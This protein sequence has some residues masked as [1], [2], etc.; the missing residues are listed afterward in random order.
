[1]GRAIQFLCVFFPFSF[2]L[3]LPPSF[4]LFQD[5]GAD[6]TCGEMALANNVLG[7]Q[8]SETAL[9][10]RHPC[11]DVFG[12]QV[13][14]LP[15]SLLPSPFPPPS[16]LLSCVLLS[17]SYTEALVLILPPSLPPSL[18]SCSSLR[19]PR[20][21]RGREGGRATPPPTTSRN[22]SCTSSSSSSSGS[23]DDIDSTS[24]GEGGREGGLDM[25]RQSRNN[26]R[27][28]QGCPPQEKNRCDRQ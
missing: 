2:R 5:L 7:G 26:P 4:S 19:E 20:R 23:T 24:S 13:Q 9:L 18:P 3:S 28:Q 6:I 14:P 25:R 1:M 27:V 17:L 16:L 11:E 15:P 12:I 22:T 10:R 8:K 21:R